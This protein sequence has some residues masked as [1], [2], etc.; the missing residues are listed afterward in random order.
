MRR[1]WF[2][3]VVLMM[4]L[5]C[6]AQ[7]VFDMGDFGIK[8]NGRGDCTAKLSKALDKIGAQTRKHDVVLKFAPGVYNFYP[9]GASKKKY[10]ISNH[11]QSDF[12][13][14]GINVEGWSN[15]VIE[16]N[17][18]EFLFH[19]RMLPI[20]I[21]NNS[22][23]ELSG[24]HI[25]FADTQICQV[26]VV[27]N[28]SDGIVFTV[29][30]GAVCSVDKKGEFKVKG[31]DWEISPRSAI[32]FEPTTRRMVYRSSDVWAPLDS[33]IAMKD[34][35]FRAPKWRNK[36][37][38]PGVKVALRSWA[39]PNPGIFL[40]ESR[41]TT[42]KN[43]KVHYAE[44][45]GLLA[46]LCDSVSLDGF[47]VC[48]RGEDDWR[49]YTT[50]ADATH[51]S[52]CKGHISSVN[53]LYEN[54]MDDAINVHGTYLKVVERID[55]R[56][57]VG[58]YMHQ[59]SYGFK[60]GEPGDSVQ[61]VASRTMD[62]TGKA[63]VIKAIET[64]DQ[65]EVAG[66]KLMKVT[67]AAPLDSSITPENSCGME[68]LAWTPSVEFNHNTVRNNR[69]RGSLF[70]TPRRVVAQTNLF[71]HTSGTAILLCGDCNGWFETGACRNVLIKD[72]TFIN[73]L[74]SMFQFTEAI[75]SIY[76][77][78]PNLAAQNDYFH[79]GIVIEG[80]RFATFDKPILYA[81][82]V[83]GL[84]FR[85]NSVTVNEDYPAFHRNQFTFKL[86]RVKNAIIERNDFSHPEEVSVDVE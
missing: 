43:V 78:I 45:M 15:L 65:S 14:V 57:V 26:T 46:Q 68:N 24:V 17:G 6:T 27:S 72:N 49:Y 58:R 54:M 31:Y 20:A 77:E 63:N 36:L 76:P 35:S 85:N 16:G 79:S 55:D 32:A 82:S 12:K 30:G 86:Q 62:I 48:L 73:S 4:G 40:S 44:G 9:E 67:F 81:K 51:F 34:G 18:A 38:V 29:D 64:Y 39:R 13:K 19:G 84:V 47:A 42:L 59:Q 25:D 66:A 61:F 5:C 8:P 52:G 50:Q 1:L 70:S 53:G 23:C 3:A 71:D 2:A 37:L 21:V 60:W 22:N 28:G 69:A 75:I 74:T 7:T 80:N 11:D 83:N 56:T 10:F 41:A 33:V